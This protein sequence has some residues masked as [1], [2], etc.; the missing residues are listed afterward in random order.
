VL[1][2]GSRLSLWPLAPVRIASRGLVWPTDGL[3]LAPQ[4]RIGTSNAV[5]DGRVVLE[6]LAP[7]L[8]AMVPVAGVDAVLAALSAAPD[9]P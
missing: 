3:E 7:A 8:L 1:A 9:W 6:P 5:A 4:G 2:P